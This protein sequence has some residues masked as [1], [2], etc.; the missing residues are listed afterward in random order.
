[1]WV[2]SSTC[3]GGQCVEAQFVKSSFCTA[4]NC[5][6]VAFAASFAASSF[7]GTGTCVEVGATGGTVLVRDNKNL[8]QPYLEISPQA[9]AE[10]Q[11]G[12]PE[13]VAVLG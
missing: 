8:D 12:L 4:E 1:M 5:A 13:L 6:E 9:W 10:F 2:R 7:C 11:D 3:S